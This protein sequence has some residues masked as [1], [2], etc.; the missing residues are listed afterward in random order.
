MLGYQ[1]ASV[2]NQASSSQII[3][4]VDMGKT[5]YIQEGFI[6]LTTLRVVETVIR[7]KERI[8]KPVWYQLRRLVYIQQSEAQATVGLGSILPI[9]GSTECR[10]SI[11]LG[12]GLPRSPQTIIY[13]SLFLLV[14][15][16]TVIDSTVTLRLFQIVTFEAL[17]CHCK[18][19]AGRH[20]Q[21]CSFGHLIE[22][23]SG[24]HW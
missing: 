16:P 8:R 11:I 22:A 13:S 18:L 20:S 7:S 6:C 10:P 24:R 2:I 23:S 14:R 12:S 15:W 5:G 21:A 19:S 1:T 17:I 9:I 4:L 3:S